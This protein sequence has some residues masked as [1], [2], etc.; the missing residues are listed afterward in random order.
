MPA[1][2]TGALARRLDG[3][4]A[5]GVTEVVRPSRTE[6]RLRLYRPRRCRRGRVA[7]GGRAGRDGRARR[8]RLSLASERRPPGE[9]R[10]GACFAGASWSAF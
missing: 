6:A 5:I 10:H 1:S 7:A 2:F 4:C 8:D 3:L 9:K